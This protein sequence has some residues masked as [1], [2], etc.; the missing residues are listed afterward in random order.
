MKNKTALI[1]GASSGIGKA[2]AHS[3]ARQGARLILVSR[4]KERLAELAESLKNEFNTESLIIAVDITRKLDVESQLSNL[5][6]EWNNIDILI[7]NA[8]LALGSDSIQTG[9]IENWERMIDTNIKGLLYVS[10]L[11]IPDMIERKSGHIVNIGSIAGQECY[12]NGNVYCASKHAVRA[13]TKSMRL[14]LLGTSVRVSEIAP[15]AV[16]T[17]FSIVRWN[18]E[19]K[20]REFYRDFDPLLAEDVAEAVLFCLTRPPHVDIAEITILPSAQASAN[21][22]SRKGKQ[23]KG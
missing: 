21:Y 15:G 10:R 14:D 8:G 19:Q 9:E 7:N 20:A 2:C 13:I 5:P 1:T 17:E 4:R 18:D 6:S 23:K 16:E 3:L 11:L 22:I 12:P